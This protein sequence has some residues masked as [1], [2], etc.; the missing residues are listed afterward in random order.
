M[1][2]RAPRTADAA[3]TLAC[4]RTLEQVWAGLDRPPDEHERDCPECG[5]ARESL[6]EIHEVAAQ[7]RD[8]ADSD[9]EQHPDV[10]VKASIMHVVRSELRGGRRLPLRRTEF[11][12]IRIREAA[13]AQLARDGASTIAG[14]RPRGCTVGG[15]AEPGEPLRLRIGLS[16]AARELSPGLVERIRAAVIARLERDLGLPGAVVDLSVE[17]VHDDE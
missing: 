10:A 14:V 12:E 2:M 1:E 16:V 5:R 4:G 15:L 13:I 6:R 11:G 9:P 7:W 3:G 8:S 17:D